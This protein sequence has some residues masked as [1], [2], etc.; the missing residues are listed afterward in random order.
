MTYSTSPVKIAENETKIQERVISDRRDPSIANRAVD[1]ERVQADP[2]STSNTFI[3]FL[4]SGSGVSK[5]G[6]K[7]IVADNQRGNR[8]LAPRPYEC[9]R[10]GEQLLGAVA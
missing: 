7:F 1:L 5:D 3:S 4:L 10:I 2:W 8:Y 9:L 6:L